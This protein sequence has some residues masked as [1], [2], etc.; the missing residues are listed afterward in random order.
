MSNGYGRSTEGFGISREQSVN[1]IVKTA[2]EMRP[3]DGGGTEFYFTLPYV[4]NS[5]RDGS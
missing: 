3:A 4:M 2:L 5:D 1:L